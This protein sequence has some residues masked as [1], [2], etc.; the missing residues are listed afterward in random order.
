LKYDQLGFPTNQPTNQ[1]NQ[2]NQPTMPSSKKQSSSASKAN[3]GVSKKPP[4]FSPANH[5]LMTVDSEYPLDGL[6]LQVSPGEYKWSP[7]SAINMVGTLDDFAPLSS[8]SHVRLSFVSSVDVHF[9]PRVGQPTK[10]SKKWTSGWIAVD[11]LIVFKLRA[12]GKDAPSGFWRVES[13]GLRPW[14]TDAGSAS[15]F[16][17]T[18]ADKKRG[19]VGVQHAKALRREVAAAAAAAD[20]DEDDD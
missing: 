17:P 16:D 4:A 8:R 11:D 18:D 20:S 13:A 19:R 5:G 15:V 3:K 9:A 14:E 7:V 6:L 10:T 2:P 12:F 1:T